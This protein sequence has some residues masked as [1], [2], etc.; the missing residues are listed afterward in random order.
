MKHI[1][2]KTFTNRFY[3]E[4]TGKVYFAR[5][6]DG[7]S[8]D[9]VADNYKSVYPEIY[10][11]SIIDNKYALVYPESTSDVTLSAFELND[12]TDTTR[13]YSIDSIHTPRIVYNSLN[14][15]FKITYIASD[16]ND[17]SHIV[18]V[19][20]KPVN[21]KLVVASSNRYEPLNNIT[22]TSTF[23]DTT[24]FNVVS[25][26]NGTYTKDSTNFTFTV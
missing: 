10:E 16:K 6:K 3:V 23:G 21:N 12:S 15:L 17:F 26:N 14:N 19:S 2:Y 22:R 11:Y 8:G 13:N 18:D 9:P 1:I 4:S 7:I 25:A 5:F 20:F 24:T